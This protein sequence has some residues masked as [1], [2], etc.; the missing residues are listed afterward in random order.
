MDYNNIHRDTVD[1]EAKGFE[2]YG[3]ARM[4]LQLDSL[5]SLSGDLEYLVGSNYQIGAEFQSGRYS[6]GFRRMQY[7]PSFIDKYYYGNHHQWDNDFSAIK[8]DELKGNLH[9][10]FGK[11]TLK[12]FAR[13]IL[14]NDYIYY[15]QDRIPTQVS[16]LQ[17]LNIGTEL[18]TDFRNKIHFY[19]YGMY[20]SVE[21]GSRDAIRV[22]ELL[23]NAK[24]YYQ[25]IVFDGNLQFQFGVDAHWKNAYFANNYDPAIQQFHIQ[26]DFSIREFGVVDIFFNLKINRGRLFLKY[27]NLMKSFSEVGYFASPEYVGQVSGIDFGFKWAFY[28]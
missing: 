28:D 24:L 1:L 3:G 13:W 21:G 2:Q 20:A 23:F 14:L 5:T 15:D 18:K 6:V 17:M 26:D 22:P 11:L 7:E 12:P 19:L 27:I 16:D 8:V 10:T 4:R 9:L 25:N